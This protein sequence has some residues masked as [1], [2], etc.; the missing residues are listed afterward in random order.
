[1]T[2][3]IPYPW[4]V[5]AAA[6]GRCAITTVVLMLRRKVHQPTT[7]YG[8]VVG[9]SDGTQARV[10]RETTVDDAAPTAPVTLIV[11]FRIRWIGGN[12]VVHWLFRVESVCNTVLFVGFPGFRSK[13]WMADDANHRYRGVYD[14]DGGHRAHAYVRALWWPLMVISERDSIAYRIVEGTRAATLAGADPLPD[15]QQWWRP[16]LSA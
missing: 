1:M 3:P 13:L 9:F 8:R 2:A 10:Y 12:R 4:Y 6:I 11:G 16:H 14:W 15:R 7:E 5:A